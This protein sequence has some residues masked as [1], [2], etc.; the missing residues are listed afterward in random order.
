[1]FLVDKTNVLIPLSLW[2]VVCGCNQYGWLAEA[3]FV[4]YEGARRYAYARWSLLAV[5]WAL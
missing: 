3:Y 1:V 4:G 2:F 5:Y